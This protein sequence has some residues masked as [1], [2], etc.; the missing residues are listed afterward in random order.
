[1]GAMQGECEANHSLTTPSGFKP[2]TSKIVLKT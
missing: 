2:L 1:M